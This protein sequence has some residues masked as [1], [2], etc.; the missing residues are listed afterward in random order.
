MEIQTQN[1]PE[2]HCSGRRNG[3]SHPRPPQIDTRR[4]MPKR[5][6]QHGN[7]YGPVH[8]HKH[9]HRH[10]HGMSASVSPSSVECDDIMKLSDPSLPTTL[11]S[12]PTSWSPNEAENVDSNFGENDASLKL[13][14]QSINTA[15]TNTR[16]EYRQ[17]LRNNVD[18]FLRREDNRN[19][20]ELAKEATLNHRHLLNTMLCEDEDYDADY[21]DANSAMSK[22]HLQRR[23]AFDFLPNSQLGSQSPRNSKY[24]SSYS[25]P[26][27]IHE[28]MEYIQHELEELEAFEETECMELEDSFRQLQLG[29]TYR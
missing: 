18:F 21:E 27:P 2:N 9:T 23:P 14:N 28:E 3:A 4:K 5:S 7:G 19:K 24:D 13:A 8:R 10:G 16:N 15:T 1:K 12:S 6:A 25:A 26:P 22:E 29:T 11:L 20:Y 17:N